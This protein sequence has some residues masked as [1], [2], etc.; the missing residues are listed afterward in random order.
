[1]FDVIIVGGGAAGLSTALV[2]GRSRRRVLVCDTGRP[3]NAPSLGV[4]GFFSRD[5]IQP[6]ELLQIGREQLH[7]YESVE[8]RTLEVVDIQRQEEHFEVTLCDGVHEV[9]KKLVLAT[10]VR[11]E[12]PPIEGFTQ[13][14]GTGVFHCPYCYGWEM[15][16]QPLAIYGKGVQARE[17]AL[18]LTNWSHDLVLCSD[19]PAELSVADRQQLFTHGIHMHEEPI[20][21]L[22]GNDG[23]L[24]RIVF[25]TGEILSRRGL[26]LRPKRHQNS[27]FAEMLGCTFKSTGTVGTDRIVDVDVNGWTRIPG[28]Y[29]IGDMAH[30]IHWVS[31]A[32]AQ[33]ASAGIA[34]SNE[35]LQED[36]VH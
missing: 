7:P 24:E 18:L 20:A 23:R 11:D 17:L 5:G 15:R 4:H 12:L 22:E 13:L 10:G 3:R 2:L 6:K 35:L 1:M 8:L 33:G 32:A 9:A 29:A 19:G 30:P 25:T 21:R 31:L 14:W 34:L 28:L 16:D 27:L 26:F 36:L